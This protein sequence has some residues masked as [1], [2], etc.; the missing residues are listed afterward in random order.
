MYSGPLLI[1]V[2]EI[3]KACKS[4]SKSY[5]AEDVGDLQKTIQLN[6][7]IIQKVEEMMTT[8]NKEYS[9]Q[10]TLRDNTIS[11]LEQEVQKL[12]IATAG[13]TPST[14]ETTA[15]NK[16]PP[17]PL[18]SS[19]KNLSNKLNT[20]LNR[21]WSLRVSKKDKNEMIDKIHAKP[22]VPPLTSRFAETRSSLAPTNKKFSHDSSK[23][24]GPGFSTLPRTGKSEKQSIRKSTVLSTKSETVKANSKTAASSRVDS[25]SD[26]KINVPTKSRNEKFKTLNPKGA[27]A[28]KTGV[29]DNQKIEN[30]SAGVDPD[31]IAHLKRLTEEHEKLQVEYARLRVQMVERGSCASPTS[32]RPEEDTDT[33]IREENQKLQ[34]VLSGYK[35]EVNR[36]QEELRRIQRKYWEQK[37]GT[38]TTGSELQCASKQV[39]DLID[40]LDDATCELTAEKRK[41]ADIVNQLG[42]YIKNNKILTASLNEAQ[43]NVSDLQ[44]QISNMDSV[45][46]KLSTSIKDIESEGRETQEFLMAERNAATESLLEAENELKTNHGELTKYQAL[47]SE[48]NDQC[49]KLTEKLEQKD[50]YVQMLQSELESTQNRARDMLLSQ[51]A[52]ITSASMALSE[53]SHCIKSSMKSSITSNNF[54]E[55]A[56]KK[57]LKANGLD[58]KDKKYILSNDEKI[59]QENEDFK[60]GNN[61]QSSD[62]SIVVSVLQA[63]R[64]SN[65]SHK[66]ENSAQNGDEDFD[67]APINC[68]TNFSSPFRSS[69]ALKP[70]MEEEPLSEKSKDGWNDDDSESSSSVMNTL[71]D[72]AAGVINQINALNALISK[73]AAVNGMIQ[74]DLHRKIEMLEV[75]K[76]LLEGKLSKESTEK[77]SVSSKLKKKISLLEAE[78]A[79]RKKQENVLLATKNKLTSLCECHEKTVKNLNKDIQ[80]L[81]MRNSCIESENKEKRQQLTIALDKISELVL[82]SDVTYPGILYISVSEALTEKFNLKGEIARLQGQLSENEKLLAEMAS[83]FTRNKSVLEDNWQKA[84]AE[85]QRLDEIIDSVLY[86]FRQIPETVKQS[87]L[88]SQLWYELAGNEDI[89]SNSQESLQNTTKISNKN[90]YTSN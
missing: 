61:I 47:L 22:K 78:V 32:E 31:F 11:V 2:S 4:P 73:Y 56:V 23:A 21:T 14:S 40:K 90:N 41:C 27:V 83:K 24:I 7:L 36:L 71:E 55:D 35:Q 28:K 66:V 9:D 64:E 20:T 3:L 58:L 53:L 30:K 75:D 49:I 86:I 84:E 77:S 29:S 26:S 33:D 18:P 39:V 13:K 85:V 48:R 54:D 15:K 46:Q 70:I 6:S 10:L 57:L 12:K 62:S 19:K 5:V 42:S 80:E 37:L 68:P 79:D 52:E 1:V 60:N 45:K 72:G 44:K 88:L 81:R 16:M 74:D 89:Y 50:L 65:K 25:K 69:S 59:N 82:D 76:K 8:K 67:S 38:E 51:G 87:E 17:P 43:K 34:K 63:I